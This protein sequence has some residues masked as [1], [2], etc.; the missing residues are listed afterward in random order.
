[1]DAAIA[2]L[3]CEGVAMP[4]SMGLGGGFLMT[5]YTRDT[6][7]VETLDAREAAPLAADKY[8]YDGNS[9]LS[10]K[11]GLS[12]AVP[13]ELKGYWEAHKRYGKLDWAEL[14]QPTVDLCREGHLVTEYL[15]NMFSSR[16][17]QLLASET[18][19]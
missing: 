11:G 18:L 12:I 14:V 5:I 1:M 16:R 2:T 19:R 4:Q 10:S 8:M 15:A 17:S 9:S 7:K 3:F 13:G 6:Q